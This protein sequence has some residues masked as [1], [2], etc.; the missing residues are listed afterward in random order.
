MPP[1]SKLQPQPFIEL[2]RESYSDDFMLVDLEG[3]SFEFSPMDTEFTLRIARKHGIDLDDA[4]FGTMMDS[5]WQFGIVVY[6]PETRT[7]EIL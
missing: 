7:W 2:R 1:G 6:W 4:S 5:L 3:K